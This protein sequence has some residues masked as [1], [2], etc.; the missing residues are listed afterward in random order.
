[1]SKSAALF[2]FW[3]VYLGYGLTLSSFLVNFSLWSHCL[4]KVK[5]T[6]RKSR[7]TGIKWVFLLM[8][9]FQLDLCCTLSTV[10]LP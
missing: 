9:D 1:M 3:A 7:Q 2:T 5:Q 8:H 4:L 6:L 10:A